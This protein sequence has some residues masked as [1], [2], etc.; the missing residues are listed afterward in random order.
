MRQKKSP[1][2]G[3]TEAENH[4]RRARAE[5]AP[6]RMKTKSGVPPPP[7]ETAGHGPP[8]NQSG[9]ARAEGAS[10]GLDAKRE[11]PPPSIR[12][13]GQISSGSHSRIARAETAA[14]GRMKTKE[15]L[16]SSPSP[17][18]GQTSHEN[19]IDAARAETAAATFVE[20]SPCLP[21]SPSIAGHGSYENQ[22]D[23]AREE[24]AAK[25]A[26]K[27]LQPL[28]SS[29]PIAG[30]SNSETQSRPAREEAAATPPLKTTA[31]L[32]PSPPPAIL[33][34]IDLQRQRI[35]AIKAQ[36]FGDR[37]CDSYVAHFL[38]YHTGLPEAEG[39]ALFKQAADLRTAVEKQLRKDQKAGG[40]AGVENH[41]SDAPGMDG[42]GQG[43]TE[44]HSSN[45]LAVCRPIILNTILSRAGWDALRK[46]TEARMCEIAGQFPV[47]ARAVAG[48]AE[49][50][51][52]VILAEAG[53]DLTAYPH[54]MHLWKR[55]GLA[56]YKGRAMSQW[57]G[58]DLTAAE[59]VQQ[60][61]NGNR[62]GRIVG[63]VGTPL[64]MAKDRPGGY[65]AVY[66]ARRAHTAL[67]HPDWTKAH[68]DNDARRIMLKAFI[69]DLW[70]WWTAGAQA[71][72][73]SQA[74]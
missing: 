62:L 26:L 68:S 71:A 32:L 11:V 36:S 72:D 13:A 44:N 23:A 38:G 9:L 4:S 35:H 10:V 69:A 3:Q 59:W 49:L 43:S 55:L 2:A 39:K 66:A 45:A 51:L 48:F 53:N 56:P 19:Q 58:K 21:S 37:T 40:L 60:G 22:A 16:P 57:H 54:P 47:L 1:T 5:G 31:R 61:Y 28:P 7:N 24:T 20:T 14:S 8:E 18:A 46:T 29:P 50:G 27:T 12:T 41:G 74:A 6:V 33:E 52:A 42:E 34:L 65:G 15:R 30:Y 67:T 73:V 64:F 63:C 17:I 25:T 70:G